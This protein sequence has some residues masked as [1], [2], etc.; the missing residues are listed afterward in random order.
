MGNLEIAV[1]RVPGGKV[2]NAIIDR[3]KKG[4]SVIVSGPHGNFGLS[5]DG[6][7]D[8]HIFIAG[9]S[10]ITPIL[11]MIQKALADGLSGISL[12]YGCR[13]KE[14]VMFKDQLEQLAS[15][16]PKAFTLNITYQLLDE[17]HQNELL[18][19][20]SGNNTYYLCGP[21]AMMAATQNVLASIGVE[22]QNIILEAFSFEPKVLSGTQYSI[23]TTS[24]EFQSYASETILEASIRQHQPLP[25]ACGMGQCGTCKAKLAS[26]EVSWN[27]NDQ[28]VLLQHEIE[29]GYVLTCSGYAKT[30][31]KLKF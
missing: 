30:S 31:L 13:S 21:P 28:S 4:S 1:K 27:D 14:D 5:E 12:V 24:G 17:D 29:E 22:S 10:G 18:S 19:G 9:G 6:Q 8:H 16:Y 26:G 23:Q 2:S 11:S 15:E 20:I 25:F 3:L 7:S